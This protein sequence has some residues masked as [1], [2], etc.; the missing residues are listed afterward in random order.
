MTD[1]FE[2]WINPL[3][4]IEADLSRP[5]DKIPDERSFLEFLANPSE[6]HSLEAA[7][8]RYAAVNESKE[9][10]FVAPNHEAFLDKLVWPLRSAKS[11][12]TIGNFISTI[13]Q[14]GMVAE[15]VALLWY[16]ISDFSVNASPMSEALASKLFGSSFEK[17][18][19]ERRV[20]ILAAFG[21]ID[22]AQREQF[23]RVRVIRRRYLHLF[24]QSHDSIE[25]DALQ[26]FHSTLL[27]VSRL[28]SISIQEGKVALRPA[29]M[30]YVERHA[31]NKR[32]QATRE[33]RAPDT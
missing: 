25:T 12:Y 24:S 20:S 2:A 27:L 14:C 21:L 29:L 7:I 30:R 33:T 15:M 6:E 17:L 26:A 4:W 10:V 28:M 5:P 23:D 8:R 3:Q 31:P 16:E 11:S 22:D 32:V 1:T 19:Q 13:A 9:R 18:G